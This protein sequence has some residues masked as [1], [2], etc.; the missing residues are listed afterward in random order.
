[1]SPAAPRSMSGV[2]STVG[3]PAGTPIGTLS[4]DG[5]SI[6]VAGAFTNNGVF[7]FTDGL[8]QV[9]GN[10]QP[11]ASAQQL[12][13]NGTD[14]GDLPTLELIGSG[15][16]INVT[17]LIVGLSE[18]GQL[19]LRQGRVLNLAAN[20]IAIGLQVG[21][22]GSISVES[23]AQ[24][25]T[26]ANLD[27][28]GSGVTAGGAGTLDIAGGTV[29]AGA[30]R[31]LRDGRI[32]LSGGTLAANS[33]PV[34]DGQFNWT[35]GTL[36]FDAATDLDGI[37]TPKLLGLDGTLRAGQ[38]LASTAVVTLQTP[39]VVDGGT[40]NPSSLNNESTLEVRSGSATV[41]GTTNN[42]AGGHIYLER[43]LSIGG[44]L[45][46]N[47]GARI[48]LASGTGRL[49][50]A[51]SVANSGL[52]TGDG[53]ITNA[54]TNSTTGK[55]RVD[56]GKTLYF[57]GA[58]A[59]NAGELNLQGGTLDFT[60]AIT[61]SATGFIA[62]RGALYTGGLT[63][64]GVMAFSGG[65]ADIHGDTTLNA[66]S[67]IVTSGAGSVTTFFDDVVHNGLEIFTG[68][69]ASTVIFGNQTGAGSFTGTG[70]VYN[71]GDL[72]PATAPPTSATVARSCWEV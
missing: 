27:V 63:N 72:R 69:S 29:D 12:N 39:V 20:N 41:T 33:L 68:A 15:S 54:V 58:F 60:G 2:R 43:D 36:R 53:T 14:S 32:N 17:G 38:A 5:G 40:L 30:L 19:L 61:N 49:L 37:N 3:D 64:N 48:T 16:T 62:G 66:G 35:G 6:F 10:F 23:G 46:N 9:A 45:T 50:G 11:S 24:L 52:V 1:M 42:S 67:R 55:I 21:S 71:I 47:I 8:L 25:L 51:G 70:T 4:L 57:T 26:T 18:R 65:T 34:L 13:I 22:E 59:A 44:T 7:N 28:G 31:L 56:F